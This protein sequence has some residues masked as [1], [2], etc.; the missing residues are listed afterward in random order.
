MQWKVAY[1][2]AFNKMEQELL[3]KR[4]SLPYTAQ[5]R[6][7]LT[8]DQGDELRCPSNF[9]FQRAALMPPWTAEQHAC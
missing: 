7:K 3:A 6:D 2:T 9:V 8:L 5:P 4:T 1:L